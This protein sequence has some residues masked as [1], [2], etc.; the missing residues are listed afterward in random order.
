[1]KARFWVLMLCCL[2]PLA[3]AQSFDKQALLEQIRI[4]A[5]AGYDGIEP[6]MRDIERYEETGQSLSDL[7]KRIRDSSL[8]VDS[9]IGFARWIV[10]DKTEREKGLDQLKRDMDKLL[11]IGGHRIAA[12]PVGAT[13]TPDLDLQRAAERY[14]AIL[15]LGCKHGVIP[16][17]ELWGFSQSLNRLGELA[18]VAVESGHP[19]ACVLPDVYHIGRGGSR[20]DGLRMF[21]GKSIH[22]FHVNDYPQSIAREKLTDAHRVYPGDGDAPLKMIFQ[23][24]HE[25]GCR[26]ALSLELFN[27]EYWKQD[28]LQVARTGL[29]KTKAAVTSALS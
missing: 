3:Q 23:I 4:A 15:E 6:W 11:A 16:Q 5:D 20:F 24:L 22:C 28:A 14:R 1:M 21:N 2:A 18:Y 25:I 10:D 9:A 8:T 7:A 29:D 27:R 12:P 26:G 13:D 17:L 19:A